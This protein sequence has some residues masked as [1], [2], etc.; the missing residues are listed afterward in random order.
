MMEY[1]Y[2]GVYVEEIETV[3]K[4]IDGVSVSI[5]E[6]RLR[7]LI[8]ALQQT[9]HSHLPE[10]TNLNESDPGVTLL[11][12]FAW[13]ASALVYRAEQ[14]PD[15]GRMWAFRGAARLF[16]L[17]GASAASSETPKR[18]SY[19]SGQMLDATTLQSE[20]NYHREKRR[21][22]NRLL[23]GFGIV[24][25]LAVRVVPAVDRDGS[26]VIVEPGYAIDPLGEE[27]ALPGGASLALRASDDEA[28]VT[29][30]FWERPCSDP[31]MPES[32]S[33]RVQCVEE[34]CVVSLAPIIPASAFAVA[35]LLRVDDNWIV[36]P[37]FAAPRIG[38][39]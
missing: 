38:Q 27:I 25:G 15:S 17:A 5:D 2:P 28:F 33:L 18:P 30:R 32:D 19:F 35:R 10:W 6:D 3:A 34:A 31:S 26:R 16:E 20:Q 12:L 29:L 39:A 36:D 14:L 22:H 13:L 37:E 8:A 24:S 4:P 7:S 21:R 9:V 23:H 11:Q 1:L